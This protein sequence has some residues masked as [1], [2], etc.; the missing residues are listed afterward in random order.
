M[1]SDKES[2][3][4]PAFECFELAADGSSIFCSDHSENQ[5]LISA[6]LVDRTGPRTES[7]TDSLKERLKAIHS[8]QYVDGVG[9]IIVGQPTDGQKE[10][11][12]VISA[13]KGGYQVHPIPM[14]WV[15]ELMHLMATPS[16]LFSFEEMNGSTTIRKLSISKSD[17]NASWVPSTKTFATLDA[18]DDDQRDGV[19]TVAWLDGWILTG[20]RYGGVYAICTS[21]PMPPVQVISASQEGDVQIIKKLVLT[22]Q[23]LIVECDSKLVLLYDLRQL[24]FRIEAK[25][26][27]HRESR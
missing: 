9:W 17:D 11:T 23:H 2:F 10:T 12:F 16:G 4:L 18:K 6:F 7:F 13:E 22:D 25:L 27:S 1:T 20:H 26:A 5:G 21:E 3:I 8:A 19:E 14:D 15:G 24:K